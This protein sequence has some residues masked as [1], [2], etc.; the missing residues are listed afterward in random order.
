MSEIQKSLPFNDSEIDVITAT[1]VLEHLTEPAGC[2]REV[3]RVLKP[4]GKFIVTFPNATAYFPFMAL[5]EKLP[6]TTLVKTF[7]PY[8]HP[9]KTLQPIDTV[10]SYKEISILLLENGFEIQSLIGRE[11]L[12]YLDDLLKGLTFAN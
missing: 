10:Y 1:E 6:Q 3:A 5:A 7:L 2:L 9:Q 8:E 11:S 12:Q 4:G